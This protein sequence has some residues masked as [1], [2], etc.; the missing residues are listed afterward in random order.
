M[1][2]NFIDSLQETLKKG[3]NIIQTENGA[4]GLKSTGKALVDLNF[5]LAS[6]RGWN[7]EDIQKEFAK[8]YDENRELA[9]KWLFF[10]RDVRG[11][12][13]ERRTFRI[14]LE[15]IVKEHAED[16]SLLF[17]L[18]PHY[19]RYDDLVHIL[20]FLNE[21]EETESIKE[22]KGKIMIHISSVLQNDVQNKNEG[23]SVS[24]LAKWLPSANTSSPQTRKA[25]RFIIK[26]LGISE[27]QYR[28][29]LSTLRKYIDVVERKMSAKEWKEIDYSHVPSKASM[30][31]S[32][33]FKKHDEERYN[34]FIEDVK[35][36]KSKINAGALFPYEIVHQ[37]E[38]WDDED[39][40]TLEEQ[41]KALPNTLENGAK[42]LVVSDGSGSMT[43]IIPGTNVQAIDC[44]SSLAIYFS[45]RLTG[46]FKDKFITFSR[47]PQLVD[48]GDCKSLKEK[49]KKVR[50]HNEVANT[51][52]SAVFYSILKTA[53]K[54]N[55]IQDDL[56]NIVLIISDMEFD[57]GAE[58]WDET[59]FEKISD[60][61]EKAGYKLPKLVFWN[62][63]SRTSVI[64]ME[65]NELGLVLVSGFSPN[66]IKCVMSGQLDP[67]KALVDV[68]NSDRYKP[69]GE[70]LNKY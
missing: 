16:F 44:A 21:L 10:A 67:F 22:L 25:A 28:Q 36:G 11:G 39:N 68:L 1:G 58:D 4:N 23:K 34:K 43:D 46:E 55:V 9:L 64:P 8:A 69:V 20:T 62:V 54:N 63:N 5:K 66:L 53:V 26:F 59:L 41:W 70:K 52:V 61:Y 65:K 31:Y 38:W 60:D 24:L 7:A 40:P 57:E 18:I 48:L 30:I 49:I 2:N 15:W 12:A 17:D 51:N 45:E 6:F 35:E 14:I 32:N 33:A 13:G 29:I 47:R 56:P 27:K 19:G 50:Q 42:I 3:D 37:Y